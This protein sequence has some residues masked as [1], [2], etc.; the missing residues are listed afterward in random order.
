ML[1][2]QL[3]ASLLF[4]KNPICFLFQQVHLVVQDNIGSGAYSF[5]RKRTT[6]DKD[7]KKKGIIYQSTEVVKKD[8]QVYE[9]KRIISA[10]EYNTSYRSRDLTRHIVIQERISFLYKLQSFT[11]HVYETPSPGLCILHAQVESSDDETPPVV[12]LPDFLDIDRLL[13]P[14]DESKYGSYALSVIRE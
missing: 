4:E 5:I 2:C 3:T 12:D 13:E 6:V 14:E 8:G 9:T 11:I 7:G 1:S 10:R